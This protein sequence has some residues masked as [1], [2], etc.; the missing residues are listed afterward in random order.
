MRTGGRRTAWIA[1]LIVL[2]AT[3]LPAAA[4]AAFVTPDYPSADC[5]P[6]GRDGQHLGLAPQQWRAAVGLPLTPSGTPA[7]QRIVLVEY[8]QSASIEAVNNLMR[9]CGLPEVPAGINVA[10]THFPPSSTAPGLEATLDAS[11]VASA[12][13]PGASMVVVNAGYQREMYGLMA[14]A[15]EA[16]GV[17]FSSP[18][19]SGRPT[20][21][22]G[23]DFPPGGCIISTSYGMSEASVSGA[24]GTE[25]A[26][27]LMGQLADLGVI[28]LFSAGDEGS[29]G[30]IASTG[31]NYGN[32][33]TVP[34]TAA[35]ATAGAWTITTGSPHGFAAG[36]SVFVI[37]VLATRQTVL[38]TFPIIA[39]PTPTTFTFSFGSFMVAEEPVE[40]LASVDFG[41]TNPDWPATSPHVL[42]VGGTQWAPQS[43]TTRDPPFPDYRPGVTTTD[44]VWRD[45]SPNPNCANQPGY[46]GVGA[47]GSG[48][49]ISVMHARPAYQAA[50][51]GAAYPSL[52]SRRTVPDLAAL[53]GWPAY[54]IANSGIPVVLGVVESGVATIGVQAAHG[55]S[56]GDLV[57]VAGVPAPFAGTHTVTATGPYSVSY[58]VTSPD[59]PLTRLPTGGTATES[60]ASSPCSA[61]DFP[62]LPMFGTSAATPL[63][64]VGIASVNA[65]LTAQG[66]PMIDN[67]GGAMDIHRIVYDPENAAVFTDVTSGDNDLFATDPDIAGWSAMPGYDMTT[68]MGVPNFTT[69]AAVLVDRLRPGQTPSPSPS[70]TSTPTATPTPSPSATPGTT[71][72]SRPTSPAGPPNPPR[73]VIPAPGVLV[74]S[75]DAAADVSPRLLLRPPA[76]RPST[77]PRVSA[78]TRAPLALVISGLVPQRAYRVTL[79]DGSRRVTLGSTVTDADGLARLPVFQVRA[80]GDY[81]VVL[82]DPTTGA[83]RFVRLVVAAP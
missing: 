21:S 1:T 7:A 14:A 76:T 36:Q 31:Q 57:E 17:A 77:A 75:A 78:E 42:A 71:P 49:G 32:A 51:A 72:T 68:G 10:S 13:P 59:I 64:A 26:E 69:L 67:A 66:L 20:L 65:V 50:A 82:R 53:A 43:V 61:A 16:C 11:V 63:V 55:F 24:V 58:A 30:C 37:L 33:V 38:G 73:P 8:D 34:I 39:T 3:G 60:C 40:G 70:P 80:A 81:T 79:D 44:D 45:A 12:L 6:V 27:H 22:K 47:Q 23:P 35:G 54:A 46:P 48:G 56:A 5:T 4:A 25:D 74:L 9:Q 18:P 41:T 62:W 2:A 28:M 29:G 15:A 19:T 52:L 83:A